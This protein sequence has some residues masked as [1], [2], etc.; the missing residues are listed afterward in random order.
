MS[1]FGFRTKTFPVVIAVAA[2]RASQNVDNDA[3]RRE[4]QKII[5]QKIFDV[6]NQK[7][8][9]GEQKKKWKIRGKD[10]KEWL[11]GEI[12]WYMDVRSER[13]SEI[14]IFSNDTFFLSLL[15]QSTTGKYERKHFNRTNISGTMNKMILKIES[16]AAERERAREGEKVK[17]NKNTG[18]DI[19]N[20]RTL[21]EKCD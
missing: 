17:T 3:E 7:N 21:S 20:A 13:M 5:P 15:L 2:E 8:K 19:G 10:I 4:Q 14:S 1:Y 18:T 6:E 9:I 12:G 11:N 16:R